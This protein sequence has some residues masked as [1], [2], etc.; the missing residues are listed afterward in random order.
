MKEKQKKK[1]EEVFVFPFPTVT[2]RCAPVYWLVSSDSTNSVDSVLVIAT[3]TEV[4]S[5]FGTSFDKRD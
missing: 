2:W 5:R 4:R 3:G 1:G